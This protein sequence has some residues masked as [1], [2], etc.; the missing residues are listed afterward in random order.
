MRQQICVRCLTKRQSQQ[1]NWSPRRRPISPRSAFKILLVRSKLISLTEYW[2]ENAF[3]R[4]F[5]TESSMSVESNRVVYPIWNTMA[6]GNSQPASPGTSTGQF[7]FLHNAN[8]VFDGRR[9]TFYCSYGSCN[10]SSAGVFCG[11]T[12][13]ST[14][15]FNVSPS[16]LPHCAWS[17]E[18]SAR[19][20]I[21]RK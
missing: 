21:P 8:N 14:L 9:D 10:V 7:W 19:R 3:S 4:T 16:S 11:R 17:K 6:G 18:T 5:F 13:G 20:V 2:G 1:V 12:R 15:L